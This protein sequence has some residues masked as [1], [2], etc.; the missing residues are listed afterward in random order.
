MFTE[1]TSQFKQVAEKVRDALAATALGGTR[2][3]IY[4][5]AAGR[6]DALEELRTRW[7]EDPNEIAAEIVNT[8]KA[9][10]ALNVPATKLMRRAALAQLHEAAAPQAPAKPDTRPMLRLSEDA[11]VKI[12]A[13]TLKD[14]VPFGLRLRVIEITE[15]WDDPDNDD[16]IIMGH[17]TYAPAYANVGS[18]AAPVMVPVYDIPAYPFGFGPSE[19]PITL[20]LTETGELVDLRTPNGYAG[21]LH[22]THGKSDPVGTMNKPMPHIKYDAAKWNPMFA[23][24]MANKLPANTEYSRRLDNL[25]IRVI[26]GES[27]TIVTHEYAG[28]GQQVVEEVLRRAKAGVRATIAAPEQANLQ[29]ADAGDAAKVRTPLR[30]VGSTPQ[31]WQDVA[32]AATVRTSTAKAKI[33][34]IYISVRATQPNVS[35]P[36]KD[37]FL[38][39]FTDRKHEIRH[40]WLDGFNPTHPDNIDHPLNLAPYLASQNSATLDALALQAANGVRLTIISGRRT[41]DAKAL[42]IEI[43]R[44]A[45]AGVKRNVTVKVASRRSEEVKRTATTEISEIAEPW[46][47]WQNVVDIAGLRNVY[48]RMQTAATFVVCISADGQV[49]DA[50]PKKVTP[51]YRIFEER[52]DASG[53]KFEV[54]I[55]KR[56]DNE[57]DL[58]KV[59]QPLISDWYADKERSGELNPERSC[60][61]S[62]TIQTDI[63]GNFTVYPATFA[64]MYVPTHKREAL[65]EQLHASIEAEKRRAI[66]EQREPNLPAASMEY[67]AGIAYKQAEAHATLHDPDDHGSGGKFE[68]HDVQV[69]AKDQDEAIYHELALLGGGEHAADLMR[70]GFDAESACEMEKKQEWAQRA[71]RPDP[72]PEEVAATHRQVTHL[73][74]HFASKAIT[75][76]Q[77]V[78]QLKLYKHQAL[79]G[80]VL[81]KYQAQSISQ[82][83]AIS[84]IAHLALK[85]KYVGAEGIDLILRKTE[86]AQAAKINDSRKRLVE[87]LLEEHDNGMI[88][89]EGIAYHAHDLGYR[90]IRLTFNADALGE[91][92]DP[93]VRQALID[94]GATTVVRM[95]GAQSQLIG[96]DPI[97][98]EVNNQVLDEAAQL[99][100]NEGRCYTYVAPPGAGNKPTPWVAPYQC[101]EVRPAQPPHTWIE[102]LP[103]PAPRRPWASKFNDAPKPVTGGLTGGYA[104]ILLPDWDNDNGHM[105][106]YSPITPVSKKLAWMLD[107]IA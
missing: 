80:W 17:R 7:D 86:T 36:N 68:P 71:K 98:T 38:V 11:P 104:A 54:A 14:L 69:F 99:E 50:D 49:I 34:D 93:S 40:Q 59:F 87:W 74:A 85:P 29:D 22:Y 3:L 48:Y 56:P 9:D 51:K 70:K 15:E 67:L 47:E 79:V 12:Q 58:R 37:R 66:K 91:W 72:S 81:R 55:P 4:D 65:A 21:P 18:E 57:P 16:N 64:G 94:S 26:K 101:N 106:R 42:A 83:D 53:Q 30:E 8:L 28:H 27:V 89:Q 10:P 62:R 6:Q 88:S 32:D 25:A 24:W 23:N 73:L 97:I 31:H 41:A 61:L 77:F 60:T 63:D 75:E 92:V 96:S 102:R 46:F 1:L 105:R 19:R 103:A 100:V 45:T 52:I 2:S 43:A 13:I 33:D 35:G 5:A 20:E 82:E 84:I 95:H 44:R 39:L 78:K 107:Q 76:K 90:D